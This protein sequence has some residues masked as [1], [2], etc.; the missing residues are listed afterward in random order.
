MT[1]R[2][3]RDLSFE[4]PRGWED[5]GVVAFRARA[6]APLRPPT[7]TLA[8]EPLRGRGI[9]EH[10]IR[11][12]SAVGGV[13]LVENAQTDVGG[14]EALL[15]RLR[16]AEGEET[17]ERTTV[18]V[19]LLEDTAGAIPVFTLVTPLELAA[20]ARVAFADVLS[21]V[22]WT[23]G[24][25][26]ERVDMDRY[27][28][29]NVSFEPPE[30]WVEATVASYH[31]ASQPDGPPDQRI[32]VAR[33]ALPAPTTLRAFVDRTILTLGQTTPGFRFVESP[34]MEVAGRSA[35]LVRF[36]FDAAPGVMEQT[37]VLIDPGSD[38]PR[39]VTVV[40]TSSTVA[41]A[42]KARAALFAM[43]R[44]LRFGDAQPAASA[45]GRA[46]PPD[47]SVPLVPIPGTRYDK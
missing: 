20:D 32:V 38:A 21:S 19:D 35:V 34:S 16:E 25:T 47:A 41:A 5:E 13:E 12:L 45:P 14:R 3:D 18:V 4:P 40:L 39:K 43:L 46:A 31:T 30:N 37:M 2:R 7:L 23:E 29:K 17:F 11:A 44:T 36:R 26:P 10:A 42:E 9:H 15:V 33:D 1:R 22:K 24:V 28:Y 8:W 27:S 6:P